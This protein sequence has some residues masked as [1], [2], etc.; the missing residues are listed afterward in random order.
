METTTDTMRMRARATLRAAGLVLA[1]AALGATGGAYAV[2]AH[3]DALGTRLMAAGAHLANAGTE[4][5][6]RIEMATAISTTAGPEIEPD[7]PAA[8]RTATA[9][10]K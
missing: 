5:L 4:P 2:L 6:W 3:G 1:G 9:R 10:R 8:R 7:M